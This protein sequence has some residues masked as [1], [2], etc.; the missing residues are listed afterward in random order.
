LDA[1]RRGKVFTSVTLALILAVLI[2]IGAQ[3]WF[4]YI[5]R[6][7]HALNFPVLQLAQ[8]LRAAGYNGRDR[9]IASDHLLAGMLHMHFPAAPA[10]DCD[11]K[12]ISVADCVTTNVQLAE[13]AGLGW[14]IITPVDQ[15]EP[16][17]RRQA[18]ARIPD[19]DNLPRGNLRMPFRT[20]RPDQPL[21]SYDLIW[22]PA[23]TPSA[24]QP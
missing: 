1:D 4:A 6:K 10:E 7:P 14:L 3:P 11:G 16:A 19:S 22:H 5:D 2:A 18:L 8:A 23:S 17:W 21:A 20:V 13:R 12:T 15:N 9:I 24:Q